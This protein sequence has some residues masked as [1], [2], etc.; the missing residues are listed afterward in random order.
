MIDIVYKKTFAKFENSE[1]GDHFLEN[2]LFICVTKIYATGKSSKRKFFLLN[3]FT[4]R[5][6]CIFQ[7]FAAKTL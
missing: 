5:I 3:C 1:N 7:Y 6:S 4:K 2:K